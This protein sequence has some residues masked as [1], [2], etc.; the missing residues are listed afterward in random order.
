MCGFGTQMEIGFSH[1]I[2]D[3]SYEKQANAQGF[4]LGKKADYFE[5]IRRACNMLRINGYLTSSQADSVCK[6]IQNN[7]V[8]EL[9]SLDDKKAWKG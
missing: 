8:K 9:N 1:G 2:C 3:E 7:L 5:N 6:K 4:T